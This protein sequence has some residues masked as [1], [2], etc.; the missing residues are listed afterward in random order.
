MAQILF[1]DLAREWWEMFM[2]QG[3]ID[4]AHESWRQL[5]RVVMP[6]LGNKPIKK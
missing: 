5:E 6:V 3:N 4:Y 1:Q 2:L